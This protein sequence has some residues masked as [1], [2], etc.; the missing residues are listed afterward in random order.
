MEQTD[1]YL[2]YIVRTGSS[3]MSRKALL[4]LD[5]PSSLNGIQIF[6]RLD[7]CS[8]NMNE[9]LLNSALQDIVLFMLK[10]IGGILQ[11]VQ[12]INIYFLKN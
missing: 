1:V 8:L 6:D 12:I 10:E 9:I 4:G 11:S 5:R 3:Q 2:R 7:N